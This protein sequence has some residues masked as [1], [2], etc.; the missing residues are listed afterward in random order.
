MCRLI[1]TARCSA[2]I[3][4]ASDVVLAF[5]ALDRDAGFAKILEHRQSRCS[6]ADDAVGLSLFFR[7]D[8]R[9]TGRALLG[10]GAVPLDHR[11]DTRENSGAQLRRAESLWVGFAKTLPTSDG[12]QTS[13]AVGRENDSFRPRGG[14]FGRFSRHSL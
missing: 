10:I 3:P 11:Q 14:Y 5:Q 13:W 6:R 7:I 9:H 2:V 4:V 12:R 1:N 8:H